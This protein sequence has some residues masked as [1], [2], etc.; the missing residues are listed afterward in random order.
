MPNNKLKE[1]LCPHCA[2]R[3]V[4]TYKQDFFDIIK[5]VENTSVVRDLPDGRISSKNVLAYDFISEIHVGCKYYQNCTK[6]TPPFM[7]GG[8]V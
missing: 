4:C 2:H 7:K 6:N 1:T 8:N 3:E 5:A